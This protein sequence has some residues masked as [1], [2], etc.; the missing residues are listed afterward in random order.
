MKTDVHGLATVTL[1]RSHELD[2]AVAVPVD[3]LIYRRVL[4]LAGG[5]A[6][7]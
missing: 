2:C 4:P 1:Q 5:F 3:V 6:R 7:E